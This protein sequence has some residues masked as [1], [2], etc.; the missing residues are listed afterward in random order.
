M[1]RQ[2]DKCKFYAKSLSVYLFLLSCSNSELEIISPALTISQPSKVISSHT[3]YEVRADMSKLGSKKIRS[4][5]F[6]CSTNIKPDITNGILIEYGD[7]DYNYFSGELKCPPLL[8]NTTYYVR[9]FVKTEGGETHYS[10]NIVT[11]RSPS[12]TWTKLADFPGNHRRSPVTF[13][14]NGLA[15][16]MGGKSYEENAFSDVWCYNP[17]SDNWSQKASFPTIL[18]KEG[19]AAFVINKIPYLIISSRHE[20]PGLWRYDQQNDQWNKIGP[21]LDQSRII[22]FSLKDKGYAGSGFFDGS[23]F[24]YNPQTNAWIPKRKYPGEA[25]YQSHSGAIA[26][27]QVGYAGFGQEWASNSYS[28]EFYEYNPITDQWSKRN[29][30]WSNDNDFR[31]GMICFSTSSKMY[32]G[33]GRNINDF[34]FATLFEYSPN[35]GWVELNS[36]PAIERSDAVAFATENVGYVGLGLKYH[37]QGQVDKLMDFWKF[38]P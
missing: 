23:F 12:G 31:K 19:A 29:T 33:T 38:T 1:N 37:Y 30:F 14:A 27:A 17:I 11:H 7:L 34:D 25:M 36:L 24:E 6:T 15:Y 20:S 22:A 9:A 28:N 4:H 3:F 5:G 13:T 18:S 2:L 10:D 32:F 21:G 26:A 16:I 8:P 35:S